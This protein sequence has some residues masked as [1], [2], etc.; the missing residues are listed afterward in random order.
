[1]DFRPESVNYETAEANPS[2]LW[3]IS[4]F[5]PKHP[6]IINAILVLVLSRTKDFNNSNISESSNH[7]LLTLKMKIIKAVVFS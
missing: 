4:L 5:A 6:D 3:R 1:M 2:L 7:L